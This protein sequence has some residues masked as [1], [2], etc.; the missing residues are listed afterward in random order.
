M[1][2]F[3]EC[4]TKIKD[5]KALVDALIEIG[6][7]RE[8]I[9]VHDE[10]HHLYGYQGDRRK[11]K[12]NVIIRRQH[13]GGSS[14]DIGFLKK[15]DGSYEA[16]ISEYDR[17]LNTPKSRETGGFNE[18][19]VKNLTGTYAEKLYIRKARQLGYT[20]IIRK[21][22]GKKVILRLVKP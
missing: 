16:I 19:W 22:K 9:E 6:W 20:K 4:E 15:P 21:K 10:A 14:N 8:Q 18:Q 7:K 2:E 11:Q 5:R 13:I 17:G 12:A 3:V 1:S